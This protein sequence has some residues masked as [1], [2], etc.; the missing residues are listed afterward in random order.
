MAAALAA[1]AEEAEALRVAAAKAAEEAEAAAR[2]ASLPPGLA[3]EDWTR[4]QQKR[5]RGEELVR[6]MR[7]MTKPID[8]YVWHTSMVAESR[9]DEL[10]LFK[11]ATPEDRARIHEAY[12]KGEE[13]T[14]F[15]VKVKS[16]KGPAAPEV[17]LPSTVP[18]AAASSSGG[19]KF[20]A[21]F[22]DDDQAEMEADTEESMA[23]EL[24]QAHSSTTKSSAKRGGKEK[25]L[26]GKEIEKMSAKQLRQELKKRKADEHTEWRNRPNEDKL[27]KDELKRVIKRQQVSE[28]AKAEEEELMEKMRQEAEQEKSL[29]SQLGRVGGALGGALGGIASVAASA[30]AAITRSVIGDTPVEDRRARKARMAKLKAEKEEAAWD[31]EHNIEE[32]RKRAVERKEAEAKLAAQ[33]AKIDEAQAQLDSINELQKAREDRLANLADLEEKIE[34]LEL[35]EKTILESLNAG[36]Y[37]AY[38]RTTN[39]R[40]VAKVQQRVAELKVRLLQETDA[41]RVKKN[42]DAARRKQLDEDMEK[43]ARLTA[44]FGKKLVDSAADGKLHQVRKILE[45]SA[46][47][48]DLDHV[49]EDG[50]TA[51]QAACRN[52]HDEVVTFLLVEGARPDTPLWAPNSRSAICH[53]VAFGG[54]D[55]TR[56]AM[57]MVKAL[58]NH[59]VSLNAESVAEGDLTPLHL[60][61]LAGRNKIVKF[62]VLAGA[63]PAAVW[64]DTHGRQ[65]LPADM[66]TGECIGMPELAVT[67]GE[68]GDIGLHEDPPLVGPSSASASAD[69]DFEVSSALGERVLR[70]KPV[71]KPL[72]RTRV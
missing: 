25:R 54:D 63:S 27:L 57:R 22:D 58:V 38:E 30:S 70:G 71:S 16:R 53:A 8:L 4:E 47:Q 19:S 50:D 69:F 59:D 56:V 26:E 7:T 17:P 64:L 52:G 61:A 21:L 68:L 62:L 66:A 44:L 42:E 14:Y 32:E 3:A 2:R 24:A 51:L 67:L 13:D 43:K 72:G 20:K 65:V 29:R 41:A 35:Y 45:H 10:L 33:Q 37:N 60:A 49:S 9:Q 15:E 18:S 46:R 6:E 23:K 28:Q 39:Q 1:S 34:T 5:L 36:G 12:A 40:E 11:A 55:D 31:V 48:V